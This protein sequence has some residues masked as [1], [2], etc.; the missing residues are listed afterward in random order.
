M[1]IIILPSANYL[2]PERLY[3][4]IVGE[5]EHP[6]FQSILICQFLRICLE[7]PGNNCQQFVKATV[8]IVAPDW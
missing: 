7:N 8:L 1:C 5:F 6:F 3:T 2:Q 4:S